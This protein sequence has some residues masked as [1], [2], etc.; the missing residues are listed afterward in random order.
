MTMQGV[1]P[2]SAMAERPQV[3]EGEARGE[4]G[5][6]ETACP[7]HE[8]E[9]AGSALLEAMLTRENLKRAWKRVRANKGLSLIHI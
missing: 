3:A 7:R 2:M 4:R 1:W 5:R 6:E 8:D 9:G